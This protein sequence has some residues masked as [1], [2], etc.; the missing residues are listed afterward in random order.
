MQRE[1][2][3]KPTKCQKIK[4]NPSAFIQALWDMSFR[5]SEAFSLTNPDMVSC[6]LKAIKTLFASTPLYLY[7]LPP[8]EPLLISLASSFLR[9]SSVAYSGVF[10]IYPGS[11][12]HF[13]IYLFSYIHGGKQG[14]SSSCLQHLAV[15][16]DPL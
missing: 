9:F 6:I 3:A 2:V 16:S 5:A 13:T 1:H 14:L 12:T 8:G 4:S 7:L 11:S 15:A 10:L